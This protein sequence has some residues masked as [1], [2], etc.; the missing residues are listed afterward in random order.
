MLTASMTS[1]IPTTRPHS[2][3]TAAISCLFL[4]S[5]HKLVDY[6]IRTNSTLHL[7]LQTI[8]RIKLLVYIP[9][10]AKQSEVE[11]NGK[12]LEENRT[13][14][15][16]NIQ[17]ES[18]LYLVFNPRDVM[19]VSVKM[20]NGEILKPEVKVLHTIRD[21]KAVIR[22]FV[23]FVDIDEQNLTYTGKLLENS[24]TLAYYDIKENSLIEML[25]F[26]YQIFL[27]DFDGKTHFLRVC[28][29]DRGHI[30]LPDF[31][32][33]NCK[34]RVDLDKH[35]SLFQCKVPYYNSSEHVECP[36]PIPPT[37]AI[38]TLD[39]KATELVN[40]S[41]KQISM[42]GNSETDL[43]GDRR[44]LS[45]PF[46]GRRRSSPSEELLPSPATDDLSSPFW[47]DND[48]SPS[49]EVFGEMEEYSRVVLLGELR[50]QSYDSVFF[51]DPGQGMNSEQE[52]LEDDDVEEPTATPLWK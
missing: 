48:V 26:T 3:E 34:V 7:F 1:G 15:S 38:H 24:K 10:N 8:D 2:T 49:E 12:L 33:K 9:S 13:L 52:I 29:E 32:I 35:A 16:L 50:L 45:S 11:A 36:V 17:S 42:E 43:A 23:C 20:P 18:I 4:S 39:N 6:G 28:K 27:M 37:K 44:P 25:P 14:A 40:R 31:V 22:S 30:S 46:L 41:W 19:S 47:E 5:D 21:V 51:M